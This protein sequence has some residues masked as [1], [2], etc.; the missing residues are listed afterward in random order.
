MNAGLAIWFPVSVFELL[1]KVQLSRCPMKTLACT[2]QCWSFQLC[3]CLC[4]CIAIE[5]PIIHVL[6]AILFALT[7]FVGEEW[8]PSNSKSWSVYALRLQPHE[9]GPHLVASVFKGGTTIS[10]SFIRSFI[11]IFSLS[12]PYN[13]FKAHWFAPLLNPLQ[14]TL[15]RVIWFP[16]SALNS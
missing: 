6:W 9:Q 8:G 7:Y 11:P 16:Y 14:Q 10:D 2:Y 3:S 1:L 12:T 4:V 13:A 5:S 15:L